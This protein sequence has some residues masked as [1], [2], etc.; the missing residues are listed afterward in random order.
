[1]T[2]YEI[3]SALVSSQVCIRDGFINP[4]IAFG[5]GHHERTRLVLGRM[6]NLSLSG[7]KVVDVGTGSGILSVD[8]SKSGACPILAAG[9]VPD[10]GSFASFYRDDYDIFF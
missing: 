7:H 6:G 2:A 5:A 3:Y 4:G 10:S 9:V 1:M 8:A